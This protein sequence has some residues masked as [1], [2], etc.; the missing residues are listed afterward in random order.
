MIGSA[1]AKVPMHEP[2]ANGEMLLSF[3]YPLVPRFLWSNKPQ[4]GGYENIRRFTSLPQSENTSINISP[5]GEGYVNFGYGGIIFA[6]VYGLLLSGV[7]HLL[8]YLSEKIPSIILW[9]P[10]LYS[11]CLTME[12]DILSTWGS[13]V[14]CGIFVALLYGSLKRFTIQ[15]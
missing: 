3:V 10:A 7:F 13:M 9:I 6:L 5:I 8:F 2:Y 11:G 15:L 14:N 12:T 4:T 1:M